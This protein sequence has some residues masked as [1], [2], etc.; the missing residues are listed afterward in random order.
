MLGQQVRILLPFY[1]LYQ[2]REL[3]E[4]YNISREEVEASKGEQ[5]GRIVLCTCLQHT[6]S[7]APCAH[8]GAMKYFYLL[9][10]RTSLVSLM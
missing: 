6:C 2:V 1:P 8:S 9:Y 4:Q 5:G 10:V 7:H 3:L